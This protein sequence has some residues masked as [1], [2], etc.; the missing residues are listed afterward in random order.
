MRALRHFHHALGDRIWGDYGFIDAFSETAGWYAQ[1]HLAIDQGP[2]V[3]MIENART[4][5][6]W[7]LLMS[8]PEIRHGLR[9][10]GFASPHLA[11]PLVS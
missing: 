8:C 9:R 2:I 3:V 4:G 11:A 5:L 1:S 10:L 7:R 6:L